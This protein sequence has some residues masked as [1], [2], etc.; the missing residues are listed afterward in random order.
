MPHFI[1]SILKMLR[2]S[3]LNLVD[4][5]FVQFLSYSTDSFSKKM[6]EKNADQ[7]GRIENKSK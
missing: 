6:D 4:C 2:S 5:F 7:I 1:I 3:E